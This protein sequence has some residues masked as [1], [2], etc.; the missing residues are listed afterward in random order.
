MQATMYSYS[1]P[2]GPPLPIKGCQVRLLSSRVEIDI[3]LD[4]L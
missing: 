2:G 4:E 1:T 3:H